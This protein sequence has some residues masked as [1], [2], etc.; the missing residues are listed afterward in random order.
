MDD[1]T[2][3]AKS[4]IEAKWTLQELEGSFKWARIKIKPVKS[5]SLVLKRG[6]VEGKF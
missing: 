3:T 1:L 5:R 2:I 6:K 4:M